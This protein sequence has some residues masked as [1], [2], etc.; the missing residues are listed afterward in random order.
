MQR[1]VVRKDEDIFDFIVDFAIKHHQ[2]D[3]WENI[4]QNHYYIKFCGANGL[5]YRKF[6]EKFGYEP[7][8]PYT[9]ILKWKR[10]NN[11]IEMSVTYYGR[12]FYRYSKIPHLHVHYILV[13]GE[14]V[15]KDRPCYPAEHEKDNWRYWF[16]Y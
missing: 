13:N 15:F 12:I 9:N 14:Q 3:K 7:S 5:V 6:K 2:K 1:I 8:R 4:A 16:E 11:E 10:D